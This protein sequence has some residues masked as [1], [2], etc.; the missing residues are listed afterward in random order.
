MRVGRF[1]VVRLV[2]A[3]AVGLGAAPLHAAGPP[4]WLPRYAVHM[5][6]DVKG[7][8]VRVVQ[9]ATWTNHYQRPV[10]EVVFNAHPRYV[11]PEGD[12]RL[13]AKTLE[14]LRVQP[15]EAMGIEEPPLEIH[16]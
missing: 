9:E 2:A 7:H 12:V 5:D 11:V 3:L 6:V 10:R 14:L 16:T 15:G 13:V 4:D 1:M 8:Q